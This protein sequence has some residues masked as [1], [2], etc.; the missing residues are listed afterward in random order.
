MARAA[1]SPHSGPHPRADTAGPCR[2]ARAAVRSLL[3]AG[4]RRRHL[5]LCRAVPLRSARWSASVVVARP[6]AE[7]EGGCGAGR[8][9][10]EAWGQRRGLTCLSRVN[11]TRC[12]PYTLEAV[13][14]HGGWPRSRPRPPRGTAQPLT[15][16]L[17]VALL[18]TRGACVIA[19]RPRRP[20][21]RLTACPGRATQQPAAVGQATAAA[22]GAAGRA[23]GGSCSSWC[24]NSSGISTPSSPA[25]S[26]ASSPVAASAMEKT[27]DGKPEM[28]R[29]A[30]SCA[31]SAGRISGDLAVATARL[32]P[33]ANS[34]GSSPG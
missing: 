34:E 11:P 21:C 32:K 12:D 17:T 22:D 31:G 3:L 5:G 9:G 1:A 28:R 29:C 15:P 18:L 20:A 27:S 19:P 33:K 13:A 10:A 16:T 25:A 24:A 14:S 8:G 6:G 7:N 26:S 23:A 2:R 4:L 30:G